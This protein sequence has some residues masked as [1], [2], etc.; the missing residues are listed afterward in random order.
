MVE[1]KNAFGSVKHELLIHS[2]RI[3]HIPNS[4][5]K[6]IENFY[7]SI[8]VCNKTDSFITKCIDLKIGVFQGDTL[9][10]ALFLMVINPILKWI[11]HSAHHGYYFRDRPII[12][13]AFADYLTLCLE[14]KR[15]AQRQLLEVDNA[16]KSVGLTLKPKTCKSLSFYS[17]KLSD[18]SFKLQDEIIENINNGQVSWHPDLQSKS[19]K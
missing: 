9:S 7:N 5:I 15:T 19:E 17:G 18:A 4:I 1:L 3:A 8:R 11:Q 16:T 10:P 12:T 2:L 6:Y 13:L 14:N